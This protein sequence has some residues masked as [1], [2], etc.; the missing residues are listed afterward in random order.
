MNTN[1]IVNCRAVGILAVLVLI[2]ISPVKAEDNETAYPGFIPI[3]GQPEGVVIDKTGNVY[4]S[5]RASSDQVWKF[6]PSGTKTMLV[7]LGEPGG[8]A[9]GLALDSKGNVYVCRAVTNQGVYRVGN[10]GNAVLIPGTE[11]IVFPNA[12]AFDSSENIYATETFSGGTSSDPFGPGGIWCIPKGER[13]ELWLRDELLTGLPPSLFPFP[14]G[15]NGIGFCHGDLYVVNTD[16]A[17]IVR[18]PVQPDGSPGEPEIWKHVEDVPESPLYNS[19]SFPVLLDGLAIDLQ[20]NIYVAVISRN[21]IVRID[22][23]DRSQKTFAI[24]PDI[25]LDTPASLAFATD[26]GVQKSLFITNLGMFKDFIPDQSWPG[27]GL[28]NKSI[29]LNSSSDWSPVGTWVIC[30]EMPAGNMI[31]LENIQPQD[32]IGSKYGGVLKQVNVN[33]THSGLFP[34]IDSGDEL[35][36]TQGIRTGLDSFETTYLTYGVSKQEN[37]EAIVK[38]I[39]VVNTQWNMTG[40]DTIE[41]YGTTALYLSKQDSDGDGFPDE[42][43]APTICMAFPFTG[44]RLNMMPPCESMLSTE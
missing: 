38:V 25:S 9:G 40:P 39:A 10:D 13:A 20:G 19:P 42:G 6:S 5:V 27:P 43:E 35:C 21:A 26:N 30:A 14:I 33:P 36:V 3:E 4:V 28:V 44:K 7:D 29:Q 15:A 18:I 37:T 17:L 41:G 12:L 11:N 8:G 23:K 1:K 2:L 34:D 22:A 31:M 16:K 32:S 24:N